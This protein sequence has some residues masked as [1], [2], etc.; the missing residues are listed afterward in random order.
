MW[1]HAGFS[2][3]PHCCFLPSPAVI[4][5]FSQ[6]PTTSWKIYVFPRK[7]W[8]AAKID[9]AQQHELCSCVSLR[10]E[11]CFQIILNFW[12]EITGKTMNHW[13]PGHVQNTPCGVFLWPE[14]PLLW[15]ASNKTKWDLLWRL[16]QSG[17]GLV[18]R[19]EILGSFSSKM[20]STD[21]QAKNVIFALARHW[22]NRN[23]HC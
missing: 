8:I 9:N 1:R 7:N 23:P 3:F 11:I 18:R 10:V 17:I 14:I 12:R 15:N 13:K 4:P 21:T 5:E 20:I 16:S 2:R 22:A 19:R 6:S